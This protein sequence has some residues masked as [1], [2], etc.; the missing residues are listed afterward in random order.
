MFV[1]QQCV[2]DQ[3]NEI[4]N[5]LVSDEIPSDMQCMVLTKKDMNIFRKKFWIEMDR[6]KWIERGKNQN[7]K[8]T[9]IKSKN[10][11]LPSN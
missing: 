6:K 2:M 10:K 7:P 11:N 5:D 9:K 4:L 1:Q 8:T 3:L